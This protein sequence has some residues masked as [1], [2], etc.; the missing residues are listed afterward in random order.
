MLR[1]PFL[2]RRV[3]VDQAKVIPG[4]RIIG[5]QA[6]CFFEGGA[7]GCEFLLAEQRDAQVQASNS[8][9]WVGGKRLLEIF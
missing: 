1:L 4:V 8:K 3:F 6:R 7:S 9:F 2:F 5:Q